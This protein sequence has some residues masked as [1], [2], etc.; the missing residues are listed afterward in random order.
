ME[1]GTRF[2]SK[3]DINQMGGIQLKLGVIEIR[4]EKHRLKAMLI[5]IRW[6]EYN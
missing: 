6:E 4:W 1:G 2:K 3:G 5:E